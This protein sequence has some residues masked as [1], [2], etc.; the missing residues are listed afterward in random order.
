MRT[1][2]KSLEEYAHASQLPPLFAQKATCECMGILRI[3]ESIHAS[4]TTHYNA[5]GMATIAVN[6]N[7]E[8]F[9]RYNTGGC[10]VS[11]RSEGTERI[12]GIVT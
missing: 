6:E 9:L 2:E 12:V 11:T 1:H 3:L 8:V 5:Q 7:N 4:L 10:S